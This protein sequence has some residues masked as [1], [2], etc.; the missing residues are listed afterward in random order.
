LVHHLTA[1]HCNESIASDYRHRSQS[2]FDLPVVVDLHQRPQ[3]HAHTIH[4]TQRIQ[5]EV[6]EEVEHLVRA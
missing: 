6:P 3:A 5:I 4:S 2:P 1:P